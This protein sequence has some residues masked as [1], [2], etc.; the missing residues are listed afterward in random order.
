MVTRLGV[1]II[2]RD[3]HWDIGGRGRGRVGSRRRYLGTPNEVVRN[4]SF[5]HSCI[6]MSP[7]CPECTGPKNTQTLS[8]ATFPSAPHGV[9]NAGGGRDPHA[10]HSRGR[11]PG[12]RG[13][14]KKLFSGRESAFL[15]AVFG[16]YMGEDVYFMVGSGG[17]PGEARGGR[18]GRPGGAGRWA[19]WGVTFAGGR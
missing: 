4:R 10:R 11:P 3:F 9:Q 14:G 7:F 18:K 17:G 2:G 19:P 12:V 13:C 8:P 6:P 15:Y 1:F 5:A 16:V